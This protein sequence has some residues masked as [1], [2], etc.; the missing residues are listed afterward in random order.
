[1]SR[2]APLP[3]RLPQARTCGPHLGGGEGAGL[4]CIVC[5]GPRASGRREACGARCR[6]ALSRAR[7]A[8]AQRTRDAEILAVVDGIARLCGLLKQRIESA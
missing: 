1:M 4:A 5:G 3:L 6:A 8:E 2:A 7:K